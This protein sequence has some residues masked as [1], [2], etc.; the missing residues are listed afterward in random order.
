MASRISGSIRKR[1]IDPGHDQNT[2]GPASHPVFSCKRPATVCARPSVNSAFVRIIG[3]PAA[4]LEVQSVTAAKD[5]V[6]A[7]VVIPQGSLT[8][9][10][11]AASQ[12]F[13]VVSGKFYSVVLL[14]GKLSLLT[15]QAADNKAKALI[16]V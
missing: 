15:H 10:V 14:G 4:T 12:K 8:A 13:T 1:L 3:A 7:Y 9:K 11:G 16:T 2:S 6:S 5:K